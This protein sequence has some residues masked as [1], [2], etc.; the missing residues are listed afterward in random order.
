VIS[1]HASLRPHELFDHAIEAVRS[2]R[3]RSIDGY[4]E[5][6]CEHDARG[7]EV[8]KL[9]HEVF[10]RDGL[11]ANSAAIVGMAAVMFVLRIAALRF[12]ATKRLE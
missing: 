6:S 5:D 12:R 8:A 10:E 2:C 11:E 9:E 3:C 4:A 1:E 7:A